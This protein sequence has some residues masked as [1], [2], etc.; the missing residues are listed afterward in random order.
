MQHLTADNQ[1]PQVFE[2]VFRK[3]WTVLTPLR[4]LSDVVT[5]VRK[6]T[7]MEVGR[8]QSA[9]SVYHPFI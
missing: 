8:L 6:T 5:E 7:E 3:R 4:M 1:H 2:S 9:G